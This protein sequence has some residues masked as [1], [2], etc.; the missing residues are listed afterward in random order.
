MTTK[1]QQIAMFAIAAF[2]LVG[3]MGGSALATH[4][5]VVVENVTSN[6]GYADS[7]YTSHDVTST[8]DGTSRVQTWT[9]SDTVTITY[10]VDSGSCQV[11]SKISG[12]DGYTQTK[13]FNNVS[14]AINTWNA[15]SA[16]VDNGDQWEVR[17]TYN[18]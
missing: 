4:S 17:N 11:V 13:I 2:A 6:T 12:S 18:C 16:T 5:N 14:T 15:A 3:M 1:T 9:S 7:W 10:G 8:I